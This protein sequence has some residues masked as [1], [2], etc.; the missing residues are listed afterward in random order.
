MRPG[1]LRRLM[2]AAA[3]GAVLAGTGLAFAREVDA[4]PAGVGCQT[5]LWG[6]LGSQRRTLCDGP[7]GADGSWQRLR[8]VWTPAHT[9]PVTCYGRYAVTCYG[10]DYVGERVNS[11]EQ[12]P[13]TPGTVLADEPQHLV[14]A[15]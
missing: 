9:T 3:A 8:I 14:G 10:G 15:A 12:Y 5:D 4:Q 11:Q 13:V 2:A 1:K 6:F 7:V